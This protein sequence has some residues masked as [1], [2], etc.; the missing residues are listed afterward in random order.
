MAVMGWTP[1]THTEQRLTAEKF[2]E[3][4]WDGTC[5]I[6]QQ[7]MSIEMVFRHQSIAHLSHNTIQHKATKPVR[8]NWPIPEFS[9]HSAIL[10]YQ[11]FFIAFYLCLYL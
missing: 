1:T 3:V 5:L 2:A 7:M 8:N 9:L 10:A 6:M 4:L 11:I